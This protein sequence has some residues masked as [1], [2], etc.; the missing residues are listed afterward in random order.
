MSTRPIPRRGR[1]RPAP[2]PRSLPP[3]LPIALVGGVVLV[4]AIGLIAAAQSDDGDTVPFG[5]VEYAGEV[6]PPRPAV[7]TDGAVGMTIGVARGSTPEG[8][9]ITFANGAPRAMVL[10]AHWCGHCQDEVD[11]V[12]AWLAEGNAFPADVPIQVIATWTDRSRANYPPGDWLTDNGWAYPTMLDDREFTLAET[13]GLTGTPMWIF[14]DAAGTVVERTG[15][16]APA[17][18]AARLEALAA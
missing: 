17:D 8:E 5:E 11:A 4:L 7:G 13:L 3:W 6:L 9:P 16:L 12:N 10:V 14:V 15:A 1:A 2:P 18:L